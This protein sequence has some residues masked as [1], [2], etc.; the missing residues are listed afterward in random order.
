MKKIMFGFIA[1]ILLFGILSLSIINAQV[2]TASK[3]SSTITADTNPCPQYIQSA[4]DWCKGGKIV[5]GGIDE[6][7]C[8]GHPTCIIEGIGTTSCKSGCVCKGETTTCSID[9]GGTINQGIG[10]TSC[11]AG[12]ICKGETMT[13]PTEDGGIINIYVDEESPTYE[14]TGEAQSGSISVPITITSQG[15][16]IKIKSGNVEAVT[17]ENISVIESKLIMQTSKGNKEIK[18]MPETASETAIARLKL[19]LCG[20]ENNCTIQIKEVGKGNE[21]KPVYELTGNKEGKFL[22]IFKIM[23]RVQA[24]V[25]A[26]DGSVKIIKP[27][28]GFLAKEI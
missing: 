5:S 11:K 17:F 15:D 1:G 8:I 22:G 10:T 20:E 18:I 24:Q 21:T 7:G 3:N 25:D 6:N 27:W 9:N 4:P 12:C 23:T 14:Q 26:E 16:K 19:K 2:S 13:C 28:W